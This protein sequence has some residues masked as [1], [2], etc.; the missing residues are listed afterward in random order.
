MFGRYFYSWLLDSER[1]DKLKQLQS[2][3]TQLFPDTFE[4]T[5]GRM[6]YTSLN[7]KG[8]CSDGKERS[9]YRCTG[10][11][12]Y[13]KRMVKLP[14]AKTST[15]KYVP[16]VPLAPKTKKNKKIVQK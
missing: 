13:V 5:G 11:A 7:R 9:L 16:F 3:N 12:L 2:I 8:V 4:S 14:G 1:K 15:V 6:K 10:K